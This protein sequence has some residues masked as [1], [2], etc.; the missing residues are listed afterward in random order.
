LQNSHT[1][2]RI[3]IGDFYH[4]HTVQLR[5]FARINT[6]VDT[7]DQMIIHFSVKCKMYFC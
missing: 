6:A 7:E 1:I 2:T 3:L 4:N 5:F